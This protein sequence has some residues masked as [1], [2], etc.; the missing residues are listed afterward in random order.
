MRGYAHADPRV[1]CITYNWRSSRLRADRLDPAL[2]I[3]YV[4]FSPLRL[5]RIEGM[6]GLVAGGINKRDDS[7]VMI[8]GHRR[9]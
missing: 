3:A 7:A 1:I 6:A 9:Q 5:R 8:C 2:K 4:T